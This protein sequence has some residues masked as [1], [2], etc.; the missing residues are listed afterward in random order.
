MPNFPFFPPSA[1]LE[2]PTELAALVAFHFVLRCRGSDVEL[3]HLKASLPNDVF[4][5]AEMLSTARACGYDAWQQSCAW[6]HLVAV[7][8]PA[9]AE[10][11]DGTFLV[12]GA[13]AQDR[14]LLQDPAGR[15]HATVLT[16]DRFLSSWSGRLVLLTAAAP[17]PTNG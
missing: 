15:G 14:V 9:L 16:R 3:E 2:S 7:P 11:R 4:G 17:G 13:Y 1:D 12:L 5:V 10:L 6:E 8:Y